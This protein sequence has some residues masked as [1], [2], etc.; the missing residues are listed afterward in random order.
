ME[1]QTLARY[2]VPVPSLWRPSKVLNTFV[3]SLPDD[4]FLPD[5]TACQHATSPVVFSFPSIIS[6]RIWYPYAV[7]FPFPKKSYIYAFISALY[8]KLPVEPVHTTTKQ[9]ISDRLCG[10][11]QFASRLQGTQFELLLLFEPWAVK[12]IGAVCRENLYRRSSWTS[13]ISIL[14]NQK[15]KSN[16]FRLHHWDE[17]FLALL[18]TPASNLQL[19]SQPS[20]SPF[21]L[22][23][24]LAT[25]YSGLSLFLFTN[26]LCRI[27]L[28][29]TYS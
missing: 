14:N 11:Q 10:Q 9:F 24:P 15:L 25:H 29:L 4:L 19:I 1:G 27:R 8:S 6:S 18:P 2:S 7:F 23:L 21:I 26:R 5:F 28:T 13:L 20:F 16:N 17:S 3:A 12:F 22:S